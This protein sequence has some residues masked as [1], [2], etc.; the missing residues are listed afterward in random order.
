ML[1][2]GVLKSRCAL[3]TSPSRQARLSLLDPASLARSPRFSLALAGIFHTSNTVAVRGVL[4]FLHPPILVRPG[5]CMGWGRRRSTQPSVMRAPECFSS[6]CCRHH[7]RTHHHGHQHHFLLVPLQL[8]NP[9]FDSAASPYS[10]SCPCLQ[11]RGGY[12]PRI[13]FPGLYNAKE[14]FLKNFETVYYLKALPGG[15][16]FRRAP[17]DWQVGTCLDPLSPA[18]LPPFLQSPH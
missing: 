9:A 10:C 4:C 7:S 17:E 8:S 18:P 3:E 14:R 2:P 1:V 6:S 11:L 13:F 15:W 16:L 12:Y 5:S